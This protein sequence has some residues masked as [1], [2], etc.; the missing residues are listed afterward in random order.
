MLASASEMYMS[1]PTFWISSPRL[2]S[3]SGGTVV[4]CASS[5][6]SRASSVPGAVRT[7]TT[8]RGISTWR[9]E[10]IGAL[11]SLTR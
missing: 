1:L 11:A 6:R 2:C 3:S 7:S 8:T 5:P 4:A 10:S 9:S